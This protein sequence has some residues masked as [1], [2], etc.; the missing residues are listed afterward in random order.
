MSLNRYQIFCLQT[1]LWLLSKL[2][3]YSNRGIFIKNKQTLAK[4]LVILGIRPALYYVYIYFFNH[5]I[6]HLP[7]Y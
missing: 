2:T 3:Q 1:H 5:N 6:M 4:Y 7:R